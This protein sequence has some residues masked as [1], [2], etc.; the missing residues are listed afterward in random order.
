MVTSGAFAVCAG[1]CGHRYVTQQHCGPAIDGALVAA[2]IGLG[3]AV[4]RLLWRHEVK[5]VCP[6][7]DHTLISC[8]HHALFMGLLS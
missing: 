3:E 5:Q 4:A 7:R 8:G 2:K 1:E 6:V